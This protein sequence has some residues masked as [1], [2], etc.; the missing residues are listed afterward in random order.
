[1]PYSKDV[2]CGE[3][4]YEVNVNCFFD[5]LDGCGEELIVK[6]DCCE[7]EMTYHN[8]VLEEEIEERVNE[9]I[10]WV[11]FQDERSKLDIEDDLPSEWAKGHKED[12]WCYVYYHVERLVKRKSTW[13]QLKKVDE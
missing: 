13:Y 3:G 7:S 11:V 10:R 1:M 12:M 2:R 8:K 6:T 4:W 5:F 9:F